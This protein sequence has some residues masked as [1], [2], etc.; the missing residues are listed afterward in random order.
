MQSR[1]AI[2]WN[3]TTGSR[4]GKH[5]T[6]HTYSAELNARTSEKHNE[7]NPSKSSQAKSSSTGKFWR[8]PSVPW[9]DAENEGGRMEDEK[10]VRG[11]SCAQRFS[12]NGKS[13]R[14]HQARGI[15]QG[16]ARDHT[17]NPP[18]RAVYPGA[19]GR[20]RCILDGGWL[21]PEPKRNQR[22]ANWLGASSC[23]ASPVVVRP[24]KL[25]HFH[26][27]VFLLAPGWDSGG[28]TWTQDER[29]KSESAAEPLLGLGQ[30]EGGISQAF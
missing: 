8:H 7:P 4:K 13:H 15:I 25:P 6:Y 1:H 18:I 11:S 2:G 5:M 20:Q 19:K 10:G 3:K 9:S 27:A 21:V 14:F 23:L 24:R 22:G 28:M 17:A 12:E 26:R 16:T 30:R 29:K